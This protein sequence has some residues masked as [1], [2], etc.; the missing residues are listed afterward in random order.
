VADQVRTLH[1][2]GVQERH[3][4]GGEVVD[5]VAAGRALGVAVAALVQDEGVVAPRQQGQDPAV[6][7]HESV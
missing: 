7:D 3:R 2:D 5:A 4:V 6:G 1:A